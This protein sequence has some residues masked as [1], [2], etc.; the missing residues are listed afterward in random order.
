ML[1]ALLEFG[2]STQFGSAYRG[3]IRRV[4]KED[5]PAVGQVGMEMQGPE[6]AFGGKVGGGIA[7]L[8][9]FHGDLFLAYKTNRI[10]RNIKAGAI[11]IINTFDGGTSAENLT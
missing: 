10:N 7:Q 8:Q 3:E 6:S 4:R 9:W 2:R 11:K 5:P 1:N